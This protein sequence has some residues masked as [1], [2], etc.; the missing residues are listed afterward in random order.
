LISQHTWT[1]RAHGQAAL[2]SNHDARAATRDAVE[3]VTGRDGRWIAVADGRLS[4]DLHGPL[5]EQGV[6]GN[7][8]P[9][10][11]GAPNAGVNWSD[12]PSHDG[13]PSTVVNGRADR[14]RPAGGSYP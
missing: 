14:G 9:S 1:Y 11:D 12:D 6:S 7:D 2:A 3:R 13:A 8:D 10:H 4:A 5:G